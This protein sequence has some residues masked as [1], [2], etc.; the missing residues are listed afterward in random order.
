[1][2]IKSKT[3]EP[4][5]LAERIEAAQK[6]GTV[7]KL[8][9]ELVQEEISALPDRWEQEVR[10]DPRIKPILGRLAEAKKG[11]QD[12]ASQLEKLEDREP[13]LHQKLIG[14]ESKHDKALRAG[15]DPAKYRAE[16]VDVREELSGLRRVMPE[17]RQDLAKAELEIEATRSEL[18]RLLDVMAGLPS[19][20]GAS[21]LMVD[22]SRLVLDLA[23]TYRRSAV[24]ISRKLGMTLLTPMRLKLKD[25]G[26]ARQLCAFYD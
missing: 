21:G 12:L 13:R 20:V 24:S 2:L 18:R 3:S 6:A 26:I 4:S 19:A 9:A 8:L 23:D 25:K 5:K 15:K 14:L 16:L 10:S 11:R 7:M 1:M 22:L 17:V